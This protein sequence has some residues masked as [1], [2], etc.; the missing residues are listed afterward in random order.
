MDEIFSKIGITSVFL[1][2]LFILEKIYYYADTN[3]LNKAYGFEDD[4][5]D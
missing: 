1:I 2:I 5:D 4:D 3:E